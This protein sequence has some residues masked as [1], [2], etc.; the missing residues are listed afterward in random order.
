MFKKI[1]H[2]YISFD[3]AN[4]GTPGGND[5]A[6]PVAAP[7]QGAEG[8]WKLGEGDAAQPWY[9]TIPEEA[10]RQH[11]E[12]KGYT[13][14]AELAL[15]NY[16]L[17]KLQRGDPSVIAVPGTDATP[18]QM[19]DFYG[20][21]GRPSEASGYEF[22][23]AD[24]VKVDDKMLEFGRSTFHEAG[25]TPQQAQIVANKWNEFAT[26]TGTGAQEATRQQNEA[27]MTAL[28]T[29]W[30]KDL[31]AN[32]A[33]G[34]RVVDA[35]GL[36]ADLMDRVEGGIGGAALVEM[37]A[38]I[39]RKSDEGGLLKPGDNVDPTNPA[40]MNAGQAQAE[41]TK[42]NGDATFQAAY[43]DA[44]HP[45]HKDAMDRMVKLYSRV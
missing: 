21:L 41:I 20:K 12:A 15:A 25:L 38:M 42:L 7:W 17:T 43:T 36:P 29:R 11:V 2:R 23:F 8:V 32:K 22:T 33:A 30:G 16:N 35:L 45:G 4:E 31:D 10:A 26:Q 44:K 18:E 40:T 3:A 5:G 37:L 28:E 19:N 14:P 27:D 39:G 9:S 24:D 13:N 34:K 1:G 6:H